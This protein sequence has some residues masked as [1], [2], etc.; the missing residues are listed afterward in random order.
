MKKKVRKIIL[1]NLGI[2]IANLLVFSN[3]GLGIKFGVSFGSTLLAILTLLI[4][5]FTFFIGNKNILNKKENN[6]KESKQINDLQTDDDFKT[7]LVKCMA[8]REFKDSAAQAMK[9]LDRMRKKINILDEVLSQH[10]EKGSLTYDKFNNT[11]ENVEELFFDNLRKMI[12]KI[13]I[14]DQD[15]Y[16]NMARDNRNLST[17][18]VMQRNAIYKEYVEYANLILEKNENILIKLDNL[19]LEISKLDDVEESNIENLATVQEVNELIEQTKY[20]KQVGG[21]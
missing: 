20:Y 5:I 4:S 16:N 14:F 1:L 19:L 8:K 10:F 2:I 18:A 9:Q 17:A 21:L 15:E 12:L 7:E 11:I 13:T 6:K 3:F